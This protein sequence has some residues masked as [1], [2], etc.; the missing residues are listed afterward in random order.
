MPF[1][2]AAVL[3]VAVGQLLGLADTGD[4]VLYMFNRNGF[5]FLLVQFVE[6]FGNACLNVID[7][8]IA[9]FFFPE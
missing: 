3:L 8:F 6:Q 7:D 4:D 5:Y 2:S 1:V 9:A